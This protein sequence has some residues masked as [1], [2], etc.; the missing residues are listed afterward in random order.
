[1]AKY[2]LHV[3]KSCPFCTRVL[4]AL[5][6]VNLDFDMI[7][8]TSYD[9]LKTPE[10]LAMNP[11]GEA[12]V[13]ITPDGGILYESVPILRF[14]ARICP[15]ANLYGETPF[16]AAKIDMLIANNNGINTM[17][18]SFLLLVNK[19]NRPPN[20][21]VYQ[22]GKKDFY[23]ALKPLDEFLSTRTYQYGHQVTLVDLCMVPIL[24]LPFSS[25][26]TPKERA[27]FKNVVRY[28]THI[29]SLPIWTKT[30]GNFRWC[31]K[32][33][34][35]M[36]QEQFEAFVKA[37]E[38]KL[39]GQKKGKGGKKNK[40]GNNNNKN[41]KKNQQNNQK[42]K[43]KAPAQQAKPKAKKRTFPKTEFNL[44]EF[45]TEVVNSKDRAATIND[46]VAKHDPNGNQFFTF[47]ANFLIAFSFWY[48]DYDVGKNGG[49]DLIRENN[50]KT[51]YIG[52][53]KSFS[54]HLLGTW[55]V[56]GESPNLVTRGTHL[57][58]NSFFRCVLLA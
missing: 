29:V 53:C 32:E 9:S 52:N 51:G 4:L 24:A 6:A 55:G 33:T 49:K 13:L 46:L 58:V 44:H 5:N 3:L 15:E 48:A 21:E 8:H 30:F 14:I 27:K 17:F 35:R 28:F 25:F 2:T 19:K 16:D 57:A 45:K 34:P 11:K 36:N 40:G 18:K 54:R 50:L 39:K 23:E 20:E 26:V 12:P 56:Y 41:Q 37:E 31:G 42:K 7:I 47:W 1:M 38:A 43:N 10:Y 22:Q